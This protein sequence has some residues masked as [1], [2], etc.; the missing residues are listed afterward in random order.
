M[1][2]HIDF[3]NGIFAVDSGYGGEQID[4]IHLLVVGDCVAL[5]DTGVN[6]SLPAVMDALSAQGLGLEQVS[7]IILTHIHLDHAG[8]AG[9]LMQQCPN[10]TLYVH[11]RGVRHMADPSKLIAGTKAV[12]GEVKTAELYGEIQAIPEARIIAMEDESTI[13]VNGRQL[14]ILDTPGHALH[15]VCIRDS[16]TGHIFTGDTFGLS[17]RHLDNNGKQFIFATTTPVHFD[18]DALKGSIDRICSY[19]PEALYLTHYSQVRDVPR[20][21]EELKGVIDAHVDIAKAAEGRGDK[22]IN[23]IKAALADYAIAEAKTQD[24][25]LQGDGLLN[26]L[27]MD[28][29]LNAQG[30][31][32]WLQRQES[33]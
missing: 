10:A 8:G 23:A 1:A 33:H 21:A 15:H 4:A 11:P 25:R 27:A 30:L 5:I 14:L 18:P 13:D 17:Y 3:H 24:W 20:L 32:V 6:S 16:Q 7:H 31:E 9:L 12:Y 26:L 29:D 22:R 19:A 2:G 28:I